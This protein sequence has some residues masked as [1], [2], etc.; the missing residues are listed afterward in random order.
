M[1]FRQ[2]RYREQKLVLCRYPGVGILL[3]NTSRNDAM[4]VIMDIHL[5]IPSMH[6][7]W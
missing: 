1:K 7:I 5:L 2:G 4:Q 6:E 3:V